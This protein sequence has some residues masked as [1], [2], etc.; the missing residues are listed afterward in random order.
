MDLR[1]EGRGKRRRKKRADGGRGMG[2]E[3]SGLMRRE[4]AGRS[5]SVV[6]VMQRN[7]RR[8]YGRGEDGAVAISLLEKC[9]SADEMVS[10]LDGPR[11]EGDGRSGG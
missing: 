2:E 10:R 5:G 3:W 9:L 11:G 1:G 7:E 4:V 8:L 6:T